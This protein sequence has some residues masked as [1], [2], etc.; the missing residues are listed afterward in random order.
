MSANPATGCTRLAP[1]KPSAIA[2]AAIAAR[3]PSG[4]PSALVHGSLRG[5]GTWE[6]GV[7]SRDS[8]PVV[9]STAFLHTPLT[10]LVQ[11][12]LTESWGL[13]ADRNG[14]LAQ[15]H[16]RFKIPATPMV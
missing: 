9:T 11:Y 8:T 15:R 7:G 5:A 14:F 13:V 4:V 1:A 6:S 3:P 16:R 2:N 10:H 12:L